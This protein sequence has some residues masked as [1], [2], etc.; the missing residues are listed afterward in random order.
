[1]KKHLKTL[2][3]IL[4]L[5]TGLIISIVCFTGALMSIDEYVRPV[6]SKWPDIYRTLM[7]LHRWLLDPSRVVGK[8]AVGI[9]TVCFIVILL[10]GLFIWMPKR[11]K[12]VKANLLVKRKSGFSR[13]VLD[14]HR[15]WGVY[16][17]L[18]LLLLCLTGLMWSFAGYRT[19]VFNMVSVDYVPE[20][21]AVVHRKNHETGEMVRYDFN[22]AEPNRKV[23][24]WAYLL[25][26]GRCGGWFGPLLTGT[27]ALMGATLPITGYVLYIRRIR[28]KKKAK[29]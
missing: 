10:S 17:M 3:L 7:F 1:M 23:M 25:H 9:S 28:R 14:L 20:R 22:E 12:K 26:T 29:K 16:C 13:K 2:H 19:T 11:W 5:P 27:A 21:V 4:A 8:M 18:M 6:W 15:V 24:R